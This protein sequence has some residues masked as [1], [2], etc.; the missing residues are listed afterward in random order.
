MSDG[1]ALRWVDNIHYLGVFISCSTKFSCSF[2]SAKRSFYRNFNAIFG[3][4]CRAASEEV[5]LHLVKTK[6]LPILF[7]ALESC[8]TISHTKKIIRISF[9]EN[10]YENF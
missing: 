2:D 6:C 5:V 10:P 3:K 1:Q 7:Y 9:Y 8:P 4:V